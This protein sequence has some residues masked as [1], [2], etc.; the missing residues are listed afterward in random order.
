MIPVT[1]EM[2]EAIEV[3]MAP[4]EEQEDTR[5]GLAAVLAI[6]ERDHLR[7]A[8]APDRCS[9]CGRTARKL[10]PRFDRAGEIDGWLGPSCYRRHLDELRE[11]A[12]GGE[13]CQ[14]IVVP[15][16]GGQR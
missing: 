3:F 10:T 7:T 15:V 13:T 9:A 14:L 2:I 12:M 4:M 1:D 16:G 11:A 8:P 6:V 5:R